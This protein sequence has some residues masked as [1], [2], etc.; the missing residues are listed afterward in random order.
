M[1]GWRSAATQAPAKSFVPPCAFSKRR[2]RQVT[3]QRDHAASRQY[4]VDAEPASN[5]HGFLDG[6][7]EMGGLM[8]SFDWAATLLGPPGAWP[9]TLRTVV[10]LL[11]NSRHPM[12]IW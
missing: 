12:F 10:R 6:G 1:G 8:R 2:K 7:G 11:L 3:R 4:R 9:Q 5:E